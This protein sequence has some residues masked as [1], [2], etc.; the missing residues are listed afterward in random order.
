MM[1]IKREQNYIMFSAKTLVQG[2]QHKDTGTRTQIQGHWRKPT[3]N[4]PPL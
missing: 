3:K 1:I 4:K 2:N